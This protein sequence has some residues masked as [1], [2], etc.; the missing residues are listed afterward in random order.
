VRVG[1]HEAAAF[2]CKFRG[3]GF[4]GVVV[5]ASV[6]IPKGGLGPARKWALEN[7]RVGKIWLSKQI[8]GVCTGLK[9][10]LTAATP[11]AFVRYLGQYCHAPWLGLSPCRS[12]AVGTYSKS[13]MEQ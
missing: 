13:R 9:D 1:Q 5:A 3:F 4:A 2:A 12:C 11:V 7:S 6:H 10:Y 8:M